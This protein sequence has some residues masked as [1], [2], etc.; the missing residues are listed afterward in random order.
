MILGGVSNKLGKC[1]QAHSP[2]WNSQCRPNHHSA[3]GTIA[4]VAGIE[5]YGCEP[6]FA[7]AY[8]R[9]FNDNGKDVQLTYISPQFEAALKK[10]K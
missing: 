8:T 3:P 1:A 10:A 4:T 9:H 6:V 2:I 5:G 7:L